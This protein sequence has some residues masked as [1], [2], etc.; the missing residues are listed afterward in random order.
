M[1]LTEAAQASL[2]TASGGVIAVVVAWFL[3][4]GKTKTEFATQLRDELRKDIQRW[5]TAAEGF[6]KRASE[7]YDEVDGWRE[8]YRELEEKYDKL[9]EENEELRK[10]I[11]D[12]QKSIKP[13]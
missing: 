9:S 8:R 3:S 13:A 1:A 11:S 6:E 10:Q 4:K 2:I 7:L 12:C 5:Q